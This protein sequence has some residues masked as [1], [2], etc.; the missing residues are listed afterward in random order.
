MTT[1]AGRGKPIEEK[2]KEKLRGQ[3]PRHSRN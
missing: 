1:A 3:K 2:G